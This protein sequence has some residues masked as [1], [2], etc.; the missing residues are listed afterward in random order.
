MNNL[1]KLLLLLFVLNLFFGMFGWLLKKLIFWGFVSV[2]VYIIYK[3]IAGKNDEG[4][5]SQEAHK[6]YNI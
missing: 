5:V 2:L 3:A 4:Q 1:I 6:E